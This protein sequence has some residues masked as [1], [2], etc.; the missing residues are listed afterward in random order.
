MCLRGVNQVHLA[1]LSNGRKKQRKK[2]LQRVGTDWRYSSI[3]LCLQVSMLDIR[4]AHALD[5]NRLRIRKARRERSMT[6]HFSIS[7]FVDSRRGQMARWLSSSSSFS[8]IHSSSSPLVRALSP[9]CTHA[10]FLVLRLIAMNGERNVCFIRY[11][12]SWQ[13]RWR[14]P[15][16]SVGRSS[17]PY[18]FSPS[19]L[20][21]KWEKRHV[22]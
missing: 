7:M 8:F 6:I 13:R 2:C 3:Y 19:F 17:S 4:S 12:S 11:K 14:F 15:S 1:V 22:L 9:W 18:F 5:K 16:L 10:P 20:V 21:S